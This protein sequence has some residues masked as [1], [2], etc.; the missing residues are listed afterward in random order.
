MSHEDAANAGAEDNDVVPFDGAADALSSGSSTSSL[1][2]LLYDEE[3]TSQWPLIPRGHL[4][5]LFV[6]SA[7]NGISMAGSAVGS[8]APEASV[9]QKMLEQR[10]RAL[11]QR[12]Q[13]AGRG[14]MVLANE[15]FTNEATP[16]SVDVASALDQLDEH[17]M[18][19]QSR[20]APRRALGMPMSMT[21]S[22]VASVCDKDMNGIIVPDMMSADNKEEEARQRGC[23]QQELDERGIC[24]VYDPTPL[25]SIRRDVNQVLDFWNITQAEMKT[26]LHQPAPKNGSMIEC[27]IIRDRTGS[28]KY[29]PVYTMESDSGMFVLNAKKQ[30]R[31]KTSNYYI[32]MAES[33]F[34]KEGDSFLGKLRSSLLGLQFTSYD[35]GLNP[36]KIDSSMPE[37][38]ALELARQELVDVQ[39]S[40]S[41]WGSK[42]RGPRKMS[43]VLP[44]VQS[45]GHRM[46]CRSLRPETEGL[47]ALHKSGTASHLIDCF[48]N[49]PPKW[50][51]QIGAYVLNFNRRVTQ[52]SV[53][54]FQLMSRED[55]D[56]VFLQFGRVGKDVFNMDFRYPFSPFQAFAVCLSSFD[57]KLCCE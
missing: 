8:R 37:V 10:Q 49:K 6:S 53:K 34:S 39:Y 47:Y 32:T 17:Q 35:K 19:E 24:P 51:E 18:L 28:T 56:T 2:R 7:T 27:R 5:K 30:R 50:N 25:T 4:S 41:L 57:Y 31:N 26:F 55:P 15:S 48:E 46:T 12:Q 33:D 54:N 9:R 43:V 11:Q 21:R 52:A 13:S 22:P 3:S 42:P 29:Y 14:N 20:T 1:E 23:L 38:H 45:G 40:S 44:R 16:A 36:K